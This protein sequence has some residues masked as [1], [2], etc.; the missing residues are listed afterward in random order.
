[1][2][3]GGRKLM[4]DGRKVRGKRTQKGKRKDGKTEIK[5][6]E[7]MKRGKYSKEAK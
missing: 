4:P 6:R 1:M 2:R 3:E 5:E 7:E